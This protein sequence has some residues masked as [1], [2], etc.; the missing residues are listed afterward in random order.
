MKR[1]IKAMAAYL[2]QKDMIRKAIAEGGD[3]RVYT[4]RPTP[5]IKVGLF[6][7]FFSYAICWPVIGVLGW[8]A[9]YAN[10]P[11]L[12]IVGGPVVYALSSLV[13]FIGMYLAGKRYA[14]AFTKWLIK[15]LFEKIL[16]PQ[17]THLDRIDG[18]EG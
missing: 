11:L 8:I 18:E 4:N 7:I 14:T 17:S 9:F 3:F 12:A 15:A 1:I 16:G 5:K 10:L 13:F 2:A 6:L